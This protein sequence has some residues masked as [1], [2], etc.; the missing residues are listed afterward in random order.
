M[1]PILILGTSNSMYKDGWVDGFKVSRPSSEIINLSVGGSPGI[2]FLRYADLDFSA[3]AAVVFDSAINDENH[4]PY[5]G[6]VR[7]YRTLMAMLFKIISARTKLIALGFRNRQN[8]NVESEVFSIYRECCETAG[9]KFICVN[10]WIFSQF[11]RDIEVYEDMAHVKR[12]IA[13]SFGRHLWALVPWTE[14]ESY[15]RSPTVVHSVRVIDAKEFSSYSL[16]TK[17]SSFT[18]AELALLPV[19][20]TI[21]FP[22]RLIVLGL[23]FD[24]RATY[25][26]IKFHNSK[27]LSGQNF[28]YPIEDRL[29]L[30]FVPFWGGVECEGLTVVPPQ[31]TF[32][33]SPEETENPEL[34]IQIAAISFLAIEADE[35]EPKADRKL[36]SLAS[37]QEIL[38]R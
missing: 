8:V 27:T 10:S 32:S 28:R 37:V 13:N 17:S 18:S 12:D 35:D 4:L 19:G 22:R 16:I 30:K 7:N 38:V 9:G 26:A 33:F 21:E 6:G 36:C 2:Q 1:K 23:F 20:S 31:D 34:P 3:Y 11:G 25:G 14:V 24:Y 5:L 29:V 15:A